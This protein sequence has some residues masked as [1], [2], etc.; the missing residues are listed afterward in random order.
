MFVKCMGSATLVPFIAYRVCNYVKRYSQLL[1][2]HLNI[3][4]L[5][6]YCLLLP[7]SSE[8]SPCVSLL[9]LF[10][11]WVRLYHSQPLPIDLNFLFLLL[12]SQLLHTG[13]QTSGSGA[14]LSYFYSVRTLGFCF[15]LSVTSYMC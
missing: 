3:R 14:A 5:L 12:H 1:P 9:L 15:S 7:T 13:S 11:G 8:L 10:L 2:K 4:V 6:L